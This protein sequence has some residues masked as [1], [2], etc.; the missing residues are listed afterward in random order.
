[1]STL[2]PAALAAAPLAAGWSA[3]LMW[4]RRQLAA[5]HRD[6][7]TG[8]WT[9]EV[10]EVRARRLLC[11]ETLVLLAD[12]NDFKAVN[13]THG[14]AAGDAVLAAIGGRLGRICGTGVVGRLGGD[15]F[16]AVVPC[17]REAESAVAAVRLA[18]GLPVE[19]EGRRLPVSVSLGAVPVAAGTDLPSALRRADEAMYA[20]K[21][22]D[23]GWCVADETA[24]AALATVNG[25]RVGRPGTHHGGEGER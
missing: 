6:P 24:P 1:M 12:V 4:M 16:A 10:F 19:Y 20:A 3:H 15:E 14:H 17:R 25:R 13:D 5:A 18:L 2:L 23:G 8:L 21:R 7:L 9:R 11:G 22:A